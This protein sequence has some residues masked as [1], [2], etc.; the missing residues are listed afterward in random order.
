MTYLIWSKTPI[1]PFESAC[2]SFEHF[3]TYPSHCDTFNMLCHHMRVD[4]RITWQDLLILEVFLQGNASGCCSSELNI[5]HLAKSWWAC[6]WTWVYKNVL[7]N[8][9]CIAVGRAFAMVSSQQQCSNRLSAKL[10]VTRPSYFGR[11]PSYFEALWYPPFTLIVSLTW[12]RYRSI[13]NIA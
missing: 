6:C 2:M 10:K 1:F 4:L 5:V 3:C 7:M 11:V 13:Y 8:V 9:S 12:I